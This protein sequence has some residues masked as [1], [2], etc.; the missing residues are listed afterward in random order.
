MAAKA[1]SREG[2]RVLEGY[3][4]GVE[5]AT[6][7]PGDGGHASDQE[8]GVD[9]LSIK[10][11]PEMQQKLE[12]MTGTQKVTMSTLIQTAWGLL[13]H[14]HSGSEDVVFGVTVS[15]RPADLPQ[16]ESMTGLFINTLPL[17]LPIT[18][19]WTISKLLAH[20]QDTVFQ[21]R[22]FEYT[23]LPD[24][25]QLTHIPNGDSLFNSIVVFEN[26]PIESIEPYGVRILDIASHEE[27]NYDLT[28]VAVPGETLEL[29]VTYRFN[30]Y[31]EKQIQSLMQ[32]LIH[33][34]E[35]MTDRKWRH[36]LFLH[37]RHE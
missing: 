15:G 2:A 22:E 11:T 28:L 36:P 16:V 33:T 5:E 34:L 23:V 20:T 27:T 18:P 24:I 29:R 1:G 30:Q 19:E 21:M 8:A 7:L 9:Q 31:T 35:A 25:Q 13:L 3:M 17:R 4:S 14:L 37:D 26:Y 10:L 12:E 32:Q 6:P